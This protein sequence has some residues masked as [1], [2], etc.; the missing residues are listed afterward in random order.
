MCRLHRTVDDRREQVRRRGWVWGIAIEL[1]WSP[2][3]PTQ[4]NQLSALVDDAVNSGFLSQS[5]ADGLVMT[6]HEEWVWFQRE[7][8]LPIVDARTDLER[9]AKDEQNV[10]TKEVVTQT[11]DT[12]NYLLKTSVPAGQDTLNEMRTA[13]ADKNTKKVMRDVSKYYALEDNEYMYKQMLDGL[14]ARIQTHSEKC[15]LIQRLWEETSES[16]TKCYQ[17]HVSR[18][19]NVL[20]G[21]VDDVKPDVPVGEILQQKIAAISEKS[22]R[23]EEKVSMAW[24][25]F[26]ELEIP[27]D[28]RNAWIE[29]F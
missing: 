24:G 28:E 20:V 22:V 25:V 29:A 11:R 10:H 27:M 5:Y 4:F 17:G 9:L 23:I 8:I 26:E 3:P 21:F 7:R 13:W 12:Y 1:L 6:L 19:S 15:E 14:W 18:L 2:T 16:V